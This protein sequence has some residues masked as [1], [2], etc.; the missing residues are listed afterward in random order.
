MWTALKGGVLALIALLVVLAGVGFGYEQ[1]MAAGEARSFPAPGRMLTVDGYPIHLDCTGTG[2]PTVVLD[3]GLGGW[4]LDW[5]EVQPTVARSTR[6]C[7]YDR[8][9]M[10]WSSPRPAPRD[11]QHAVDELHALL[12]NGGID[13]PLLLVGHSNG[14]LR[15]LLYAAE[16]R[17]DVVGLVLVDPTPISTSA[18]QFAVLS[19]NEQAELLALSEDQPSK[20]EE[21]GQP[22]VGLIQ[23]AQPFGIARLLSDGLLAGSIYP[24]L[25]VALQPAYRAGVNR[26][27]FMSTIAAEAQQRPAS[28]DQLRQMGT[29]GDLPM[30]VLASSSP[31]AF[32]DDPVPPELSGRVSDMLHVM[33]HGSHQAIAQL[34]ATG[35][36][37]SVADTGHYIQF[38]RPDAVIQAI[39]DM[40]VAGR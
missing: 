38:D 11:A 24:H 30:V 15:V 35:H 10:G 19:P 33:L 39:Q 16:H 4:S 14:G 5:S 37:K 2:S 20:N 1:V 31:V 13:G 22:L 12:T 25:S 36:V 3:A 29:L 18:E 23:A 8:P 17:A 26:A 7:S 34:S 6:V 9:G 32:N 28:I 27:S 40:P 21:G